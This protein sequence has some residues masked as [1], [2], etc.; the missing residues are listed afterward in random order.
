VLEEQL[1]HVISR[2]VKIFELHGQQT[3]MCRLYF[4]NLRASEW[5]FCDASP[6]KTWAVVRHLAEKLAGMDTETR[7]ALLGFLEADHPADV[8]LH[9]AYVVRKDDRIVLER[10]PLQR[11]VKVWIPD[12]ILAEEWRE[13]GLPLRWHELS[14]AIRAEPDE[15]RRLRLVMQQQGVVTQ[16]PPSNRHPHPSH[17]IVARR[18]SGWRRAPGPG[19]IE[20]IAPPPPQLCRRCQNLLGEHSEEL[21]PLPG[22]G[23]LHRMAPPTGVPHCRRRRVTEI[24]DTSDLQSVRWI[25]GNGEMWAST[26]PCDTRAATRRS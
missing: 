20:P 18:S 11:K 2:Q 21:C 12:V 7:A 17:Q 6:D 4:R 10:H 1:A 14:E 3:A 23:G 24:K 13:E 16:D 5:C 22:R 19:G 9:D 26:I 15:H 8:A 25:D